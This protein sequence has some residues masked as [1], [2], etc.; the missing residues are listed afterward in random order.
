VK[1]FELE[2]VPEAVLT[3]TEP[4]FAFTGTTAFNT[5]GETD[6][7]FAGTPPNATLVVATRFDPVMVIVA[8][9]FPLSGVR[10][11]IFGGGAGATTH[12]TVVEDGID[13]PMVTVM[14][15]VPADVGVPVTIPFVGLNARPGGRP[16]TVTVL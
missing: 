9:C 5:V 1:R 13:P 2:A 15:N 3:V 11:A 4:L 8:P 12:V 16:D 7:N 14:W 6:V 10:R